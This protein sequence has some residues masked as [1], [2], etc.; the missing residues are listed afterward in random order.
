MKRFLLILLFISSA[1]IGQDI[2]LI[3]NKVCDLYKTYSKKRGI[4]ALVRTELNSLSN[5]QSRYISTL[6]SI[7]QVSHE[8]NIEGLQTF[9]QRVVNF[10]EHTNGSHF[11]E[12]LSAIKKGNGEYG[13]EDDLAK[14]LFDL[15]LKSPPHKKIL[16]TRTNKSYSFKVT[17]VKDGGFVLI[18]IFSGDESFFIRKTID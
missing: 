4:N 11:A 12:V 17:R 7:N 15:L 10:Y 1:C 2:K 3:E 18:G 13:T 9:H 6:D 16:D 14:I 8:T 5:C